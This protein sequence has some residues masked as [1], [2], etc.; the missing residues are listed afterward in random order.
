[1]QISRNMW[2]D[3]WVMLVVIEVGVPVAVDNAHRNG[4]HHSQWRLV[5]RRPDEGSLLSG[6]RIRSTVGYGSRMSIKVRWQRNGSVS[7]Y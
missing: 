1:M 6:P 3:H 7:V 5:G 2:R 4:T